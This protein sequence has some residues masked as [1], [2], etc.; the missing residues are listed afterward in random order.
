VRYYENLF[1]VNPNHEHAKL[2][3]IIDAVKHEITQAN[4]NILLI[5]EWG[6]KR[7]AYPIEN[8]KYGNYVLIQF[9]TENNGLIKDVESWLKLSP[10]VIAYMTVKLDTKPEIKEEAIQPE[11]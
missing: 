7:L 4:G 3:Q 5:D 9:E 8:H 1:I 11:A 6:K 10:D 2:S